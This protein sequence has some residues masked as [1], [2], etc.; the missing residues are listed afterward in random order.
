M[1]ALGLALAALPPA[2]SGQTPGGLPPGYPAADHDARLTEIARSALPIIAAL[3]GFRSERGR[4]PDNAS[5]AA[6]RI[7]GV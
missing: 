3:E 5:A 4:F 2:A 6:L 1:I 7:A